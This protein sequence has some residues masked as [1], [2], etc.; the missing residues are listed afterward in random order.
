MTTGSSRSAP[1]TKSAV[2][3][4]S[5]RSSSSFDDSAGIEY[6]AFIDAELAEQRAVKASFEQRGLAV[7]STSAAVVAALFGLVAFLTKS[8]TFQLPHSARWPLAVSLA[9]FV[10]AALLGLLVNAPMDYVVPRRRGKLGF[11]E[12]IRTKWGNSPAIARRR[13]ALTQSKIFDGYR[14]AN[15]KKG[16]RLTWAVR[17]EVAA[18]LALALAIAFI[19][20]DST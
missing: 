13:V 15:A 17:A 10:L 9:M 7:L 19:L 14:R 3:T 20:R 1:T 6:A 11:N 18:V 8:E 4:T 2:A 5:S 16:Q 12:L